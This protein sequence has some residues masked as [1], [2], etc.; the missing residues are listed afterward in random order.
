MELHRALMGRI[1]QSELLPCQAL[2]APDP[3]THY[4]EALQAP[5][6]FTHYWEQGATSGSTSQE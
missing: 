3:F 4:W 6:P 1:N 5:D 2:Q